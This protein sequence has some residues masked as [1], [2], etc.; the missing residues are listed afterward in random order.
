VPDNTPMSD[1]AIAAMCATVKAAETLAKTL[2]C[3]VHEGMRILLLS[4]RAMLENQKTPEGQTGVA[5]A[6]AGLVAAIPKRTQ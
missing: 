6:F 2:N 4:A 5:D 1:E 3:P